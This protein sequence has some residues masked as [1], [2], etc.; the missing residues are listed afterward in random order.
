M[1]KHTIDDSLSLPFL[2]INNNNM[3][4]DLND[5][6][7]NNLL[8]NRPIYEFSDDNTNND[9]LLTKNEYF[10]HTDYRITEPFNLYN[11][12]NYSNRYAIE[13]SDK[14]KILI[15]N[16]NIFYNNK[17]KNNNQINIGNDITGILNLDL[18][19][20][21]EQNI[22]KDE[23]IPDEYLSPYT[24]Q[25][26]YKKTEHLATISSLNN[27]VAF[28]NNSGNDE[29]YNHENNLQRNSFDFEILRHPEN[30][31]E[32]ITPT[33]INMLF[34]ATSMIPL[35]NVR[36]MI[37]NEPIYT[38]NDTYDTYDTCDTCD[39]YYPYDVYNTEDMNEKNNYTN[40]CIPVVD[41][42]SWTSEV[43]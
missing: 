28:V 38:I 24:T 26:K 32:Q 17:F 1:D 14:S 33:Y 21:D 2:S 13:T 20:E 19:V 23:N 6:M 43:A 9:D 4:N 40:Q 7:N 27:S 41:F 35:Q 10:D 11:G 42:C 3:N 16:H 12:S 37:K 36:K 30:H 22:E 29:D 18:D 34:N 39:A 31:T 5:E 25:R 15:A 8:Q